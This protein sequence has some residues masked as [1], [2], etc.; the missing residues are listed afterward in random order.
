MA[1]FMFF[2]NKSR[3]KFINI[4]NH[5]YK[6]S[7]LIGLAQA[8]AIIPGVSRSGATLSLAFLTGWDRR[9]ATKFSF[10]LGIPSI[11]L[12]AFSEFIYFY[13]QSSAFSFYPLI[14][15]IITSFFSSLL[16]IDFLL[17]FLPS[18]GL[19][20]FIYYRIIFAILILINL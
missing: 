1:S 18:N 11:T 13:N 3:N 12:A 9:D 6:H 19:I 20:L 10:L 16:A 14:I 8:F 7:L 17:K 5:N 2:A 4:S 15:G